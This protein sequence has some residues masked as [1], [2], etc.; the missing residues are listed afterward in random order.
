LAV[1]LWRTDNSCTST[2]SYLH[3]S[4]WI[5]HTE[6]RPEIRGH[7]QDVKETVEDPDFAVRDEQGVVFKYRMGFGRGKTAK[8]WLLVIE[9]EDLHGAHYVKSVYFTP[10]IKDD[11]VLC[12]RRIPAI[13]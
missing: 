10:E 11:E 6:K 4:N 5:S 13:R 3:D 12:I 7:L 1:E 9:E 8:L 2:Q